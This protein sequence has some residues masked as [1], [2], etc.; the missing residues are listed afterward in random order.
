MARSVP[1]EAGAYGSAGRG[2]AVRGGAIVGS[3]NY[4]QYN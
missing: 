2:P 3:W 4:A 1:N